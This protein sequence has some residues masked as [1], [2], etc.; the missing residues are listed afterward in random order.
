MKI[1][2]E[3]HSFLMKVA[4]QRTSLDYEVTIYGSLEDDTDS[5]DNARSVDKDQEA[6]DI[7]KDVEHTDAG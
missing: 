1:E 5:D 6:S 4:C 7:D 3:D 2:D